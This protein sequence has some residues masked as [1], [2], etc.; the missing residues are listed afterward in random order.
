VLDLIESY[1]IELVTTYRR[2]TDQ[3][4]R[5]NPASGWPVIGSLTKVPKP[6][7]QW[8]YLEMSTGPS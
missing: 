3:P 7:K 2:A 4:W 8:D 1:R 6:R 5:R